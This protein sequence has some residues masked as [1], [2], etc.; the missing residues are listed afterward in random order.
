MLRGA[1]HRIVIAAT[2]TLALAPAAPGLASARSLRATDTAHLRYLSGSGS[3]LHERGGASGTIPG[4]MSADMR[5]GPRFSGNF[6]IYA[7]GGTIRGHGLAFPKGEGVYESFSGTLTVTGGSG[8]FTR[9]HGVAKLYG[10]F[11]RNSY[12]LLV[13]T[14]GTLLY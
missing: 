8:R 3:L 11:N 7:R 9:A 1:R 10:T 12:A 6:T 2:L 4:Q 14:V 5:V 13:Q